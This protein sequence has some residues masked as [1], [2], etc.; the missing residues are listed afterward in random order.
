M[1]TLY[2]TEGNPVH[3]WCADESRFGLKTLT[4][5]RITKRGV[6]PIG[7]VQWSFQAYYL[8]G[9]VEPLTGESFFLEF[10]HLNTDCFQAFLNEFAKAYP[11]DIHLIQVDNAR[12][13]TAKR[14]VIPDQVILWFQ[15]PH[16]PEC[17]PIERLWARLKDKL[18]WQ[19]FDSLDALKDRLA[20]ILKPIPKGFLASITGQPSL[21]KV[22]QGLDT[23]HLYK[24]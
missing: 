23:S 1:A 5:R 17:N 14:L 2:H 10:S 13:H 18:S 9:L 19:L 4:R 20:E 22:L 12:F 21:S 3:Y 24:G 7:Q 15:P 6:K 8:C 16:S 11:D